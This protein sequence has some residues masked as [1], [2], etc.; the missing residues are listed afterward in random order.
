MVARSIND[1][2]CAVKLAESVNNAS[3]AFWNM[4]EN[5]VRDDELYQHYASTIYQNLGA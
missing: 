5:Y 1:N 3:S 4:G 2:F